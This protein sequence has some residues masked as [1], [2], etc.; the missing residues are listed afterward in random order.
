MVARDG[1]RGGGCGVRAPC[2]GRSTG[3]SR[4]RARS[5]WSGSRR[6]SGRCGF[7][8]WRKTRLRQFVCKYSGD[9]WEEFYESLFGYEA[10]LAARARWGRGDRAKPRVKFAPWREP[11][12]AWLDAKVRAL[13]EAKEKKK[14]EQ[15][16]EKGLCAQ[17]ENLLVARRK[18]RRT[19]EAMVATASD[20]RVSVGRK[21][22][23]PV[24]LAEAMREAA[25]RGPET[26]LDKPRKGPRRRRLR[27]HPPTCSSARSPG[28]LVGLAAGGGVPRSWMHQ[29]QMFSTEDLQKLGSQTYQGI[30]ES[31]KKGDIKGIQKK[32][33]SGGWEYDSREALAAKSSRREPAS[34]RLPCPSPPWS[35]HSG[36]GAAGLALIALVRS[37]AGRG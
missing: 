6:C 34:A 28:S 19:A 26:V 22:G 1:R 13:R 9:H 5:R 7:W 18:A 17:G 16:E 35:H 20:A 25:A 24:S 14:L 37:S 3:R 2:R 11:M 32:A 12:I 21:G 27:R 36:A 8:A 4:P 30:S 23:K 33:R 31:V 10:K 15:I 29:N